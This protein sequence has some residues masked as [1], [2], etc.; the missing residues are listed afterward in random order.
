M[1]H[2]F[3][4]RVPGA[5]LPWRQPP[6]QVYRGRQN[7]GQ[8][9][10]TVILLAS[11]FHCKY[12]V[13]YSQI[14]E[15][16]APSPPSKLVVTLFKICYTVCTNFPICRLMYKSKINCLFLKR[17]DGSTLF[18][19]AQCAIMIVLKT[20]KMKAVQKSMGLHQMQILLSLF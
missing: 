12:D 13:L 4:Q 3:F 18:R 14:P 15:P 20:V 16:P 1:E 5:Q 8:I 19:N 2:Y 17:F 7:R 10:S 11:M 9:S 6:A